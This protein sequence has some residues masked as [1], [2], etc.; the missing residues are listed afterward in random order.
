MVFF[1]VYCIISLAKEGVLRLK[2]AIESNK[3]W[4]HLMP[5]VEPFCEK[6]LE[7]N[8]LNGTYMC[9]GILEL[10]GPI[11]SCIYHFRSQERG[12]IVDLLK[13][14]SVSVKYVLNMCYY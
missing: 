11:V 7:D 1:C 4:Q 10:Y 5:V 14:N 13:L 2:N 3:T 6:I 12:Q 8:G 9:P